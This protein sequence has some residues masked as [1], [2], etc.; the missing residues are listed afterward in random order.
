MVNPVAN[1]RKPAADEG[2]NRRLEG[3]EEERLIAACEEH[4]KRGVFTVYL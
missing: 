4:S 1:V 3:N 2:R